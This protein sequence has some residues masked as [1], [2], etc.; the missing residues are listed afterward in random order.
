MSAPVIIEARLELHDANQ[1]KPDST[2]AAWL[3]L[4][5]PDGGLC[6]ELG[7][8][9]PG[10]DL[11]DRGW[12]LMGG[13]EPITDEDYKVHYWCHEPPLPPHPDTAPVADTGSEA[14]AAS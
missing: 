7:E 2:T 3:V 10:S 8:W 6:W 14:R 1:D 13:T 9:R 12:Y 5:G 11:W 4:E